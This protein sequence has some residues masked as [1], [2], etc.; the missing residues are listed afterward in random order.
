LIAARLIP[1][2]RAKKGTG[3]QGIEPQARNGL[4]LAH[5]DAR[6]HHCGV[7]ALGLSFASAPE[8]I[9]NL[10]GL[11]RFPALLPQLPVSTPLRVL[12]TLR[13]KAFNQCHCKKLTTRA[14]HLSATESPA[15]SFDCAFN[16]IASPVSY[17]GGFV[18]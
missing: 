2:S 12:W 11:R 14:F 8:T 16:S 10:L 6:K 9:A 4:S 18:P 17:P 15:L 1:E 5:N 13:I 3:V 7:M